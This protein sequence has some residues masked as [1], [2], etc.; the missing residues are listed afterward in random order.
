M[1]A[2]AKSALQDEY[3]REKERLTKKKNAQNGDQV[4][5]IVISMSAEDRWAQLRSMLPVGVPEQISTVSSFRCRTLISPPSLHLL[6]PELLSQG[7]DGHADRMVVFASPTHMRTREHRRHL[8]AL[9]KS[10]HP[11]L[12][13]DTHVVSVD[14]QNSASSDAMCAQPQL[15]KEVIHFIRV[16]HGDFLGD[17]TATATATNA[18]VTASMEASHPGVAFTHQTQQ[19]PQSSTKSSPASAANGPKSLSRRQRRGWRSD[20][21]LPLPAGNSLICGTDQGR[22]MELFF[23]A[24]E[25]GCHSRVYHLIQA[26]VDIDKRNEYGHTALF[27]AAWYGYDKIVHTL[28]VKYS[29]SYS[30]GFAVLQ[31]LQNFLNVNFFVGCRSLGLMNHWSQMMERQSP[32]L[33]QCRTSVELCL[34]VPWMSWTPL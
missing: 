3:E 15:G 31:A 30:Y 2:A 6:S 27:I 20:A 1:L 21:V 23:E 25:A 17:S 5:Q 34:K 29:H 8:H 26:G 10:V 9:I 33:P 7:K 24:I 18:A 11:K 16:W 14:A 32:K 19:D 13:T 12:R 4:Q 22:R 28:K